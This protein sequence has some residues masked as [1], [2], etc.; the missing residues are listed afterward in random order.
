MDHGLRASHSGLFTRRGTWYY[1]LWE[2]VGYGNA[3]MTFDRTKYIP[4]FRTELKRH[5][6]RIG[7]GLDAVE[8]EPACGGAFLEGMSKSAHTV[9]GSAA[10][11]AFRSIADLAA[12]ME[13]GIDEVRG[14][15]IALGGRQRAALRR[16]VLAIEELWA[17]AEENG[18]GEPGPHRFDEARREMEEAFRTDSAA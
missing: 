5:L 6:Q 14:G 4:Q 17:E 13:R 8:S 11:M 18:I 3:E 9:R 15:R 16:C 1:S 12:A 7:E 2:T 10:M